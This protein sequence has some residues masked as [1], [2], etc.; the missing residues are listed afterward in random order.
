MWPVTHARSTAMSSTPAPS[1]ITARVAS[2]ACANGST[3][4]TVSKAPPSA[5]RSIRRPAEDGEQ[6][7]PGVGAGDVVDRQRGAEHHPQRDAE[8][9]HQSQQEDHESRV[10]HNGEPVEATDRVQHAQRPAESAAF[11]RAGLPQDALE[12]AAG[13]LAPTHSHHCRCT[14]SPP[15]GRRRGRPRCF[16]F[17]A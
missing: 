6:E 7:H 17:V 13:E 15:R 2:R 3:L 11:P 14:A 1:A 9:G 16:T 8:D 12:V 5:A 10:A 4:A